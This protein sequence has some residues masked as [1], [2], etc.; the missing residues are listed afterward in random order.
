MSVE[1]LNGYCGVD[2]GAVAKAAGLYG[3]PLYLYDEKT[4]VDKCKALMA[5]PSAY[6]LVVRYA[7]KANS[8]KALLK[9]IHGQGLKIDASSMNEARRAHI[10]GVAYGD[11][12]LTTQEAPFGQ[13]MR[14]L[15]DMMEQG[16]KYNVCSLQQLYNIGGFA[17]KHKIALSFRVHPGVGTGETATRNTGDNYCCFGIH[18]ADIEKALEYAGKLGLVFNHVHTHIGSG[19]SPEVWQKNIDTELG[20]IERYFP[21]AHTVSF[22]GGLREARMPDESPADIQALGSYAKGQIEGFFA[23]T[24]RKLIMEIEPGTYTMANAGYVVTSV[25]DKKS[26]GGEGLNFLVLD[27]GMELNARPLLYAS[28]HPFYAVSREG[29]LLSAEHSGKNK[30]G[31]EAVLV[32]RCCESGDSQC[33]DADGVSVPRQIAEPEIGDYVVIGGAGA[34]CSSM[35]PI[36]YNSHVQAPEILYTTGHGF[37]EIRSRQSLEQIIANEL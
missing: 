14:A 22:G 32:G 2:S 19:G 35:S 12:I 36:N 1:K 31:Y 34:Y 8:T 26:T 27:G 17:S 28:R 25:V 30:N 18:L 20:I 24:G 33:L 6:G 9:L 3:T 21:G 23:R 4:V 10:A 29:G 37:T 5:M 11:I 13:E 16:L 15:E 7:M